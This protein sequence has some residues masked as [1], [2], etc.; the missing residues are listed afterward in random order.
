M[1][2]LRSENTAAASAKD[3]TTGLSPILPE[4]QTGEHHLC[5][6]FSNRDHKSAGRK[7]AVLTAI[8]VV[9]RCV[10]LG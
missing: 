8:T 1:S 2:G 9:K 10:F 6:E 4:V 7:D 3:G 5:A